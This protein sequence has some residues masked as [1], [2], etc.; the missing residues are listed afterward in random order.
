MLEMLEGLEKNIVF[1]VEGA[2]FLGQ[3]KVFVKSQLSNIQ[4]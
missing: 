2:H 3:L 4:V 1:K